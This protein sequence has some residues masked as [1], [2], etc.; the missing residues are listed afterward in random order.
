MLS[1]FELCDILFFFVLFSFLF[2]VYKQETSNISPEV[3][4]KNKSCFFGVYLFGNKNC[5]M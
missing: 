2:L 5:I 3:I 1:V 4:N